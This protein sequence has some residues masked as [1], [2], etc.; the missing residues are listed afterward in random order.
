[1]GDGIGYE[2]RAARA[3]DVERLQMIEL[4]AA[5]RYACL[6][7]TRFCLDLPARSRTEHAFARDHG[8]ALAVLSDGAIVGFLLA[9]PKDRCAHIQEISVARNFQG[10]G[11][12]RAL[13][14]KAETWA[15]QAGFSY[16]TLTTFRDVPWNAPFYEKLGWRTFDPYPGHPDLLELIA[17][18]RRIGLD[19]APRIAM[20]KQL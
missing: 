10:H 14:A 17:D 8:L 15:V 3:E 20:R 5:R 6:T 12:G 9:V 2:I 19:A 13:L 16:A 4:D 7:E 1:M 18:E 11:L